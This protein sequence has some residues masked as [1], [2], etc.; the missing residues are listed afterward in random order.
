MKYIYTTACALLLMGSIPQK[1]LSP[2]DTVT[3]APV[4][5]SPSSSSSEVNTVNI[6]YTLPEA[7]LPGSVLLQFFGGS[8]VSI[9]LNDEAAGTHTF[10]LDGTNLS[11]SPKV[12]TASPNT[13]PSG[14]Y[15][16]AL[17]YQ[18][19]FSNPRAFILN[20]NYSFSS[21]PLPVELGEV[22]GYMEN[23]Q[24]YLLW[25]TYS[26]SNSAFFQIE[27][28]SDALHFSKIGQV[29]AAG[30]ASEQKSYRFID[31]D[32]STGKNYYRLKMV[33]KDG[34][35]KYSVVIMLSKGNGTDQFRVFPN[36]AH[37]QVNVLIA[38]PGDGNRDKIINIW[39][40]NAK[41]VKR[42][43]VNV[44]PGSNMFTVPLKELRPGTYLMQE[45]QHITRF[46]KL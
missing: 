6:S 32:P 44:T 39:D 10:T 30:D 31:T 5:I 3:M 4:L 43:K 17:S 9:T 23:S 36:P 1:K 14:S 11:S 42:T 21:T 24:S 26:E 15:A 22:R 41:I 8:T 46:I 34:S 45:G 16:V 37:E 12:T 18:D 29:A 7:A 13:I 38:S 40:M 28:S 27:R 20:T 2:P 19:V 33:D 25:K 35:F